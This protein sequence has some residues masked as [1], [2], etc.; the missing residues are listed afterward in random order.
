MLTRG[1]IMPNSTGTF[2]SCCIYIPP[3]GLLAYDRPNGKQIAKIESGPSQTNGEFHNAFITTGKSSTE[4]TG[5]NLYE[6]GDELF[7]VVY[8]DKQDDFLKLDNGYWLS[9]KELISKGLMLMTWMDYLIQEDDVLGWY[10]NHPALNLRSEP[11]PSAEI[12]ATLKGDLWEITPTNETKGL[13]CK[14]TVKQYRNHPCS[15][16]TVI[17]IRTLT[18]WI[19]ILSDEQTPNV[20]RYGGC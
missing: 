11:T 7:A 9:E 1:L 10:A 2:E 8:V 3:S 17:V 16:E 5:T 14:V 20:W 4:L 15:G 19:K 18:G 13:W 6:V 12:L